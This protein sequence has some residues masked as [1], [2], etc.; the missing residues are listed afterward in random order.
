MPK[1]KSHPRKKNKPGF[2]W[3]RFHEIASLHVQLALVARQLVVLVL[4]LLGQRVPLEEREKEKVSNLGRRFCLACA[5]SSSARSGSCPWRSSAGTSACA[6]AAP[7]GP[8][9]STW[10]VLRGSS[11]ATGGGGREHMTNTLLQSPN[12]PQFDCV[13]AS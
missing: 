4:L 10:P 3:L 5:S 7:A 6:S 9:R 1:K 13:E 11:R 12:C 8:S 2:F